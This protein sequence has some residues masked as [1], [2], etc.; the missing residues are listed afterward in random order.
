MAAPKTKA[1]LADAVLKRLRVCA[2][3]QSPSANDSAYV[4]NE[5]DSILAMYDDKEMIYW[6]NTG[7]LVAEIPLAA[8]HALVDILCGSVSTA[9]GKPEPTVADERG[10]QIPCSTRGWRNLKKH[11]ARKPSGFPT[12]ANFF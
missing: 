1:E 12:R 5:Y 6:P 2:A 7:R 4:E 9:Y 3:D 11:I 10:N 8:Y